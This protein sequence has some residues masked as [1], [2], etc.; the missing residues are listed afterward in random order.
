MKEDESKPAW[1]IEV[2]LYPGVCLGIRSY[3]SKT[4]TTHVLYIPFFDVALTIYK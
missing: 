3:P 4:F 2:G 1:E